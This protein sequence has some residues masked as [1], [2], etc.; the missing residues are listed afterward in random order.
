LEFEGWD[1]GVVGRSRSHRAQVLKERKFDGGC[2][3]YGPGEWPIS[4]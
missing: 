4:S 2:E 3:D 1:F